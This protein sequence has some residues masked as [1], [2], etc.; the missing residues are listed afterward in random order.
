ME[1]TL[2]GSL[3]VTPNKS[4]RLQIRPALLAIK[5]KRRFPGMVFFRSQLRDS[6]PGFHIRVHSRAL[7][8]RF[9]GAFSRLL[10][11]PLFAYFAY[12]AVKTIK[13]ISSNQGVYPLYD[14]KS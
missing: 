11:P 9:L 12:L 3:R 4:V 1:V 7:A 14:A 5:A 2:I 13:I 10:G 6:F 8:V